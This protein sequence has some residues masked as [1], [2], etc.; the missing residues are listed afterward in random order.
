[1]RYSP[2]A[3]LGYIVVQTS[4]MDAWR[5]Y[6]KDLLGMMPSKLPLPDGM[7][8]Y[9]N[10]D[11]MA[12]I[13][14]QPGENDVAAVG[15][16]VAG[17]LE[18]EDLLERLDNAGIAGV[19]ITGEEAE[20]RGVGQLR[21]VTDPSGATVEF[22]YMPMLD[23]IDRFVS[24]TGVRFVTGDQGMGHITRA[25]SNYP[26]MVDFYVN[27]LG[28]DQRE[29]IEKMITA[30]FSSP[31]P[32]Q[33]S[34]ALIDGHGNDHFHHVMFEVDTIDDVGR[35]LDRV[36]NGE[37]VLTVGLGRHFND[38][39]TSFYMASPSGLQV[40]YGFDGLRVEP[41]TW[42]ENTQ[43]GVGGASLW[44]HHPVEIENFVDPV[45][46]GFERAE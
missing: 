9:R 20:Q 32:R 34:I 33:H 29:T 45:A 41:G 5:T 39:M 16:E 19:D 46:A 43:G 21:R 24:P 7:Y 22:G 36:Q 6:A 17:R 26:E 8:A 2:I 30:S 18:W 28:F 4:E 42:V 38:K 3:G 1:M 35:V 25:V 14:L 27:V 40:E 11:H 12:R 37:A 31:N 13:I 10:D 23:S 15:W 44:G